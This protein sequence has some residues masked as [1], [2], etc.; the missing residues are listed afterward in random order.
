MSF[1]RSEKKTAQR[2]IDRQ[3]PSAVN[4]GFH[5]ILEA[6]QPEQSLV[7]HVDSIS[8][9]VVASRLVGWNCSASRS[10]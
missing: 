9:C 10:N 4:R 3:K 2:Q 5:K 1:S 8:A 7:N 6:S